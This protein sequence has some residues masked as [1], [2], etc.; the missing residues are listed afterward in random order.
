MRPTVSGLRTVPSTTPSSS[1]PGNLGGMKKL[2]SGRNSIMIDYQTLSIHAEDDGMN[3]LIRINRYKRKLKPKEKIDIL[4][5][6]LSKT[7]VLGPSRPCRSCLLRLA[8]SP[9]PINHIY[10]S[11]GTE[12]ICREKFKDMYNSPLT[13]MSSGDRNDRNDSSTSSESDSDSKSDPTRS[14]SPDRSRSRNKLRGKSK[15]KKRSK[16]K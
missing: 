9:F 15:K 14:Q 13:Y 1:G 10:Y 6:R 16:S 5:I 2:A 4:V 11:N 7:G 3:N 12:E 8:K